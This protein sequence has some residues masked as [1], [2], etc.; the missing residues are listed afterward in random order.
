MIELNDYKILIAEDEVIIAM[1]IQMRLESAGYSVVAI[2]TTGEEAVSQA[3][4]N[5]PH[6]ALMDI[7]LKGKLD[8]IAA[9]GEIRKQLDIPVVYL[10]S[11]SNKTVLER[12]KLTEAYAYLLKPF[13]ERT[14]LST[15]EVALYKHKID[16]EV[17]EREEQFRAI[18]ER[19]FDTIVNIDLDGKITYISPAVERISGFRPDEMVGESIFSYIVD[20]EVNSVAR[21]F[22]RNIQGETVGAIEN[23]LLCKNG[24][25]IYI[26][27]NS[28]PI[29]KD[30]EIIGIQAIF[31]DIS[32]R[33]KIELDLQHMATHDYLT[34][35]PNTRLFLEHLEKALARARRS[36]LFVALLYV[37][38][39]GFK[40]VNDTYGHTVGDH[41]LRLV[42]ERL[43]SSVRKADI[44]SRLGGDEFAVLMTD[45]QNL[46]SVDVLAERLQAEMQLPFTLEGSVTSLT[47]SI[48][49][50][51]FPTDT[52]EATALIRN[53]DRAMYYSKSLGK[54][55]YSHFLGKEMTSSVVSEDS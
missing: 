34:D 31:R 37:D 21:L 15:I 43:E 46:Q 16:R 19:S 39:D 5:C 10:T 29:V 12:A 23:R 3:L 9:A 51:S 11:Y 28:L 1:D 20:A 27:S 44:V 41:L 7:G 17:K 54:N 48:G 24:S 42:A 49:I 50:S 52:Q 30:G 6:L 14:L 40:Q 18:V 33:K 26:E 55:R 45:L 13:E 8:G 22:A 53:A 36:G 25:Y 32:E 35:L 2:V 4:E 38:L 47:V